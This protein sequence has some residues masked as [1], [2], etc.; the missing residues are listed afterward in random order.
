MQIY[1]VNSI[2]SHLE[3]SIYS[4]SNVQL[5][6]YEYMNVNTRKLEIISSPGRRPWELIPWRSVRRP[7]GVNF[8]NFHQSW[9]E[10]CL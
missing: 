9:Y 8:A 6:E 4:T 10:T 2:Y 5:S 1:S 3:N 7:S